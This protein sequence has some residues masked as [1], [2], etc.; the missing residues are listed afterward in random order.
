MLTALLDS[1]PPNGVGG[2]G[3]A[4]RGADATLDETP[5]TVFLL[6]AT[7]EV[8]GPLRSSEGLGWRRS[9]TRW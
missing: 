4:S 1:V 8:H 5:E 6:F 3:N 9:V 2:A 7:V